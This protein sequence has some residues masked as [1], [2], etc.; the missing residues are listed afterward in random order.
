MLRNNLELNELNV[1]T[2][3]R[4]ETLQFIAVGVWER[5]GKLIV[6]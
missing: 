6:V 1:D 2:K 4:E 3:L 5:V